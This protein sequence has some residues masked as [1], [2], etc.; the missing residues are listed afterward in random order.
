MN[1]NAIP[2]VVIVGGNLAGWS[3][4]AVVANSLSRNNTKVTLIEGPDS[5]FE[6]LSLLPQ[7]HE[8]HR[9]LGITEHHLIRETQ[10]TFK[11]GT[12]YKDWNAQN[13]QYFDSLGP[14]G[15]F[16]E[17]VEF[18]HF[19]VKMRQLD[20]QTPYEAYSLGAIAALKNKF[21]HPQKDSNSLLSALSYSLHI[22]AGIYEQYLSAYSQRLGVRVLRGNVTDTRLRER[23]G[24]IESI[25]LDNGERI[26]GD[27]FIDCS[28]NEALLIGKALG[29]AYEDWS[30]WLPANRIAALTLERQDELKPYT[31]ITGTQNGWLREVPLVNS[32]EQ[33]FIYCDEDLDE[34]EAIEALSEGASNATPGESR[35]STFQSGQRKQHWHKNCVA[36]GA[37]AGAI[38]PLGASN[39]QLVHQGLKRFIRLFP[40]NSHNQ[41]LADEYNRL[42]KLEHE[43]VLDFTLLHYLSVERENAK[44][45]TRWRE[46]SIP[47]SLAHKIEFFECHGQV[48][49]YKQESFKVSHYAST[50]LG[51]EMWPKGYDPLLDAFDLEELKQKFGRMR[52]AVHD[53]VEK[54]PAHRLYI[55]K[56]LE[57][58]SKPA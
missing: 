41:T 47:E 36:F 39:L 15:G 43:N 44:I 18:Q 42:T 50:Y 53:T 22:D 29:V 28:G 6:A 57:S 5:T 3:A 21:L 4:A 54:M 32:V 30:H 2:H 26:E 27:L 8:F 23:D 55:E 16:S 33:E 10:A 12:H 25:T 31:T 24:F 11:L 38:E 9:A 56:Y 52:K 7:T 34:E 35:T 49:N 14:Y 37:A 1:N 17:F 40:D 13:H 51:L 48:A 46:H 45:W 20:D 58:T 19:A